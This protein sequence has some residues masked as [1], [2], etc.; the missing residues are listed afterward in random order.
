MARHDNFPFGR[1]WDLP[2][3]ESDMADSSELCTSQL[4]SIM[5]DSARMA[6]KS[7][8]QPQTN[9]NRPLEEIPDMLARLSSNHPEDGARL[10]CVSI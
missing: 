4:M 5:G 6:K 8:C 9:V 3:S 10:E 2:V 1:F 7:S